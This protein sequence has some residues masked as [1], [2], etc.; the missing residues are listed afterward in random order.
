MVTRIMNIYISN[1]GINNGYF[2]NEHNNRYN[3]N[4]QRAATRGKVLFESQELTI[5]YTQQYYAVQHCESMANKK[6][7]SNGK[8]TSD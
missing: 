6:W 5:A 1:A 2:N 7:A 4:D 8:S 3:K